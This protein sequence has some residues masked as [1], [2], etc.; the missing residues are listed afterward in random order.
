MVKKENKSLLTFLCDDVLEL[1]I[2]EWLDEAIPI[3]EVAI[4]APV[5]STIVEEKNARTFHTH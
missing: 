2:N 1:S 3:G 4:M 5:R